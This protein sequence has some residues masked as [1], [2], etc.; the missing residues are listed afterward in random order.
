MNILIQCSNRNYLVYLEL[1]KALQTE[2]P[3]AKF[4]YFSRD[5][6][7]KKVFEGSKNPSFKIYELSNDEQKNSDLESDVNLIKDFEQYSGMPVW[8]MLSADRAI[9]WNDYHGNYGTFIQKRLIR[10]YNCIFFKKKK[11]STFI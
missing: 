2:Y 1:C 3:E 8:K 6:I 7:T 11:V 4:G 10:I 5:E 9:G